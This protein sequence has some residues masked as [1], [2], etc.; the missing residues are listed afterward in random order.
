[1]PTTPAL[2]TVTARR[3]EWSIAPFEAVRLAD[4]PVWSWSTTHVR[5]KLV[6]IEANYRTI[7][8]EWIVYEFMMLCKQYCGHHIP[9]WIIDPRHRITEYVGYIRYVRNGCQPSLNI[10]SCFGRYQVGHEAK[11]Q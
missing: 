3:S 7:A 10:G 11:R 4:C 1:M 9:L 5:V 8:I 2:T 6:M